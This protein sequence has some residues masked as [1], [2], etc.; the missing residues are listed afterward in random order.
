[1]HTF[2]ILGDEILTLD[3]AEERDLAARWMREAH[4]ERCSVY[5][6]GPEGNESPEGRDFGSDGC[7]HYDGMT[8]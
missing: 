6:G 2:I 5:R 8:G 1:M 3:T 4:V 7:F